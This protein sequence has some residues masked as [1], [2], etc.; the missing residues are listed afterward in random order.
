[1]RRLSSVAF[2]VF[3][4]AHPGWSQQRPAPARMSFTIGAGYDQGD[5]GTPDISRAVYFPFSFRY[6]AS[7]FE[8]GVSS[9][10]ARLTAPDGVQLIDGV[11]T[12]TG[13]GN[14]PLRESGLGDTV[15]RS[16]LFLVNDQGPE[17]STPSI[18]PFIRVKL[19]TAPEQR[20]LGTGKVDY[21]FGVELDKD[22]GSAFVFGDVGYT[23]VGKIPGLGLQ[24]RPL[25]SIGVGK[26]LSDAL[27]VSTLLDWRRS[28]IVG[29]PNPT[30]LVGILSYRVGTTTISPNAF[31]GLTDGSPDFGLGIQMRFR[32]GRF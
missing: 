23:V 24:N 6:T 32:F 28:I 21:G 19:P 31:V 9:S 29:A 5:F 7:Q 17:S 30:D 27:S 3:F 12:Q 10:I 4:V 1:M 18:T 26:Q 14:T 22:L 16:R 25:A 13:L 8:V 2:L 20:G 15:F 11:P